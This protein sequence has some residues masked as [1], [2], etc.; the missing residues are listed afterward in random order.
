MLR[1]LEHVTIRFG[2]VS[3]PMV[4]SPS[5]ISKVVGISDEL[6]PQQEHG[7][8]WPGAG[9]LFTNKLHVKKYHIDHIK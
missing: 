5:V 9:W 7:C 1:F 3:E 6:R 8:G 4:S 2:M